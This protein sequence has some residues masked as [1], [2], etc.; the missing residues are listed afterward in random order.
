MYLLSFDGQSD[1]AK[2]IIECK[3][4]PNLSVVTVCFFPHNS[5]QSAEYN[6]D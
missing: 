3:M 4:F 1:Y 2:V 5:L 6:C